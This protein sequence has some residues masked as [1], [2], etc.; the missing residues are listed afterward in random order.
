MSIKIIFFKPIKKSNF[1]FILKGPSQ[2]HL[3]F[4]SHVRDLAIIFYSEPV[5]TKKNH[6]ET[7]QDNKTYLQEHSLQ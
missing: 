7:T 5:K 4:C 3:C 2:P 6:C 1:H